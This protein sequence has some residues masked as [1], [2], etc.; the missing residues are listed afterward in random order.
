MSV[1]AKSKY[2]VSG[3]MKHF[4]K[5]HLSRILTIL[6]H[7]RLFTFKTI[8]YRK[9]RGHPR[10]TKGKYRWT[11]D[12]IYLLASFIHHPSFIIWNLPAQKVNN[13]LLL[14]AYFIERWV[15]C[16]NWDTTIPAVHSVLPIQGAVNALLVQIVV[17]FRTYTIG[18]IGPR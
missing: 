5:L 3:S 12:K 9:Y 18:P 11:T 15:L 4:N 16:A 17:N 10:K 2:L 7:S 1:L 8:S 6:D 13:I 14:T